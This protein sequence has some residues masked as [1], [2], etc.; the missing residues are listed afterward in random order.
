MQHALD[1][2]SRPLAAG[3][4][5]AD[6]RIVLH[7]ALLHRRRCIFQV[8]GDRGRKHLDVADLLGCGVEQHVA[9]F[10]RTA[11]AP[12]LEEILQADADLALHAADRLLQLAGEDRIG[13]LDPDRVLQSLVE[14]VHAQLPFYS[15][16]LAQ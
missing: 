8:Q 7:A 11:R 5:R 10:G 9:I 13:L 3:H 12:G 16:V 2:V 6:D 14:I 1:H 15:V 4:H